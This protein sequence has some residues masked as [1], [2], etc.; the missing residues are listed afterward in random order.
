MLFIPLPTHSPR[1]SSEH[2]LDWEWLYGSLASGTYRIQKS[3]TDFRATGD[4][5]KYTVY[6]EF[7]LN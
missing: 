7:I 4:Y 2:E 6:A 1:K 3:V 5:D